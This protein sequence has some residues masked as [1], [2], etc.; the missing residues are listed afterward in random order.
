MTRVSNEDRTLELDEGEMRRLVDAAM[1]HI[2]P[3]VSSLPRQ[4]AAIFEPGL[5]LARSTIEPMPETG[6]P[7][8]DLFD[9]LFRRLVPHTFNTAS[10]GY[11]AFIPG[12]GLFH[13]AVADLVADSINRYVGVGM[14][15]PGLVRLEM[16]VI[17]WFCD[18]VGLPPGAGGLLTTG[19]SMANLTAIIAARVDRLPEMF[20]D[21]VIY[22][23]DQVHHSI[24]KSAR[25]AGFPASAIRSIPTDE[26][27]RIRVDRVEEAIASDR[28]AGRKP[29][30][31]VGSAGT[32]N[33]G[34]IDDL[35]ALASLAARE[36]LWFHVDAAYG[37]FFALTERGREAMRGI[38]RADSLSLDPH[39]GLF[40]P[41][42]TGSLLVR[43]VETLRR[44]HTIQADYMP[45]MQDDPVLVDFCE[46]SPELSRDFRG[47]RVWLPIRMHGIAPFRKNLDEKL[48][49]TLYATEALKETPGIEIV[50]EPQLSVVAFWLR[51]DGLEGDDLDQ[52]NRSLIER[53]N[54]RHRVFLTGTT[55]RGRFAIRICVL[56]FR[57]HRDRVDAALEDI[58]AAIAEV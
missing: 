44:A 56:S 11:L 10:P 9:H 13:S 52:L 21:G 57:T 23:S 24:T 16:N 30:L 8:A 35:D 32:T 19:G 1:R 50:T 12:G 45:A 51:R 25:V 5:D 40:L 37:G 58:R 43:D 39:K 28:A 34:A 49:L 7:P 42:G 26:T 36:R 3:H 15:S 41:Y 4:P 27:F 48:D 54:S 2:V 17:R 33:T 6:T 18:I 20:F 55:L 14:A 22:V 53:V 46:I 31:L 38:E 47:L 29:F